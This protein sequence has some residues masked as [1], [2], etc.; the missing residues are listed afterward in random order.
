[1]DADS[2]EEM[3]KVAPVIIWTMPVL[4]MRMAVSYMKIKRKSRKAVKNFREGLRSEGLPP[5]IT[6]SLC[7][8][9]DENTS[10]FRRLV[11]SAMHG[12]F[13]SMPK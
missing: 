2:R 4:M 9:Y 8:I 5:E 10:I 13:A 7:S 11:S 3:V 12:G 1:M 6:D